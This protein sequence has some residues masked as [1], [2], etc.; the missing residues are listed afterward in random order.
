MRQLIKRAAAAFAACAVVIGVPSTPRAQAIPAI[1]KRITYILPQWIEFL[2]ASDA[3]VQQQVLELRSRIGEGPRVRIGFTTYINLAMAPVDPA[4]T[5]AIRAAL[6]GTFAQVDA[7]IARARAPGNNIPIC[8]SFVTAVRAA[9]DPLQSSAQA[10]DRRNMQWHGDQSLAAGWTTLSRYARKQEAIQEAFIREL[11]RGL[12]QRMALYPET[13]VAASGD[14]EIELS[15]ERSVQF[16]GAASV[17]ASL[18][19]D[20]SPF[21]VA[22]FRD[23]LRSLPQAK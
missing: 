3:E 5:A 1:D 17:Q 15:Y 22:E 19:A 11:G 9:L 21:A 10:E 18:I 13:L 23:W 7:A 8:L 16:G 20:Y 14:G 4:D 2:G 12:A 6:A